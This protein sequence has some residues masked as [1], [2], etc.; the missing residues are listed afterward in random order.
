[1]PLLIAPRPTASVRMSLWWQYLALLL[2][3]DGRAAFPLA[4]SPALL[5]HMNKSSW[6]LPL[7]SEQ[8]GSLSHLRTE[9]STSLH[10]HRHVGGVP[11]LTCHVHQF[12]DMSLFQRHNR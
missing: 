1:V 10:S 9:F 12:L 4:L 3:V 6:R 7:S 5:M 2:K 11:E 8:A